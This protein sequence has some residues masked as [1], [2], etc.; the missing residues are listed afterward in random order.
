MIR[1][2]YV[3]L[4]QPAKV[5]RFAAILRGLPGTFQIERDGRVI[6]ARSVLGIYCL[7][8]SAPLRLTVDTPEAAAMERLAPFIISDFM[9]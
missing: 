1:T 3:L 4:D 8:L 6:D 9:M 5:E 2:A 7:N